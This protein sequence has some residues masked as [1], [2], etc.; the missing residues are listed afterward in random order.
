MTSVM[1]RIAATAV[2]LGFALPASAQ[3]EKAPARQPVSLDG[4]LFEGNPWERT[5]QGSLI[6]VP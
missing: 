2:M 3:S 6:L 1:I 4:L 5:L